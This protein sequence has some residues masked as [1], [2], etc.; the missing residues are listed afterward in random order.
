MGNFCR[1]PIVRGVLLVA[2]AAALVTCSGEKEAANDPPP[3]T[4]APGP[5][6][7][8]QAVSKVTDAPR[9][10]DY[11]GAR[12]DVTDVS[13]R[14]EGRTWTVAGTVTNPTSALADYRI[15][16]SFLDSANSTRGLLQTNV[17]RAE[18]GKARQ[19]SGQIDLDA[20]GLQCV[21]RVERTETTRP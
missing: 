15:F 9:S 5:T 21:L 16:T 2:L 4:V 11:V 7:T 12:K 19:W 13:C 8:P 17:D 6:S 10:A 20:S 14:Q 18:A 3:T 1:R